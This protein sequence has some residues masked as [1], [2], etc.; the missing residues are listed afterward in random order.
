V[1]WMGVDPTKALVLSQV[2]LSLTLPVPMV[3]LVIF[4]RRRDIMGAFVASPLIGTSAILAAAIVLGLNGLLLLQ[5]F[6]IAAW[7]APSG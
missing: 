3:A 4:S 1:V 7:G 2:L 6:H 5:S